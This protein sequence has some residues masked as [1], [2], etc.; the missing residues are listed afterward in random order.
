MSFY[1]GYCSMLKSP[2]ANIM[3]A[4]TNKRLKSKHKTKQ[5]DAIIILCSIILLQMT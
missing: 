5:T 1:Q 4:I 3:K 2:I